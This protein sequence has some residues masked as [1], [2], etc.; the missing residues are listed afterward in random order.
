M[1]INVL[2]QIT[3]TDISI[4]WDIKNWINWIIG[5]ILSAIIGSIWKLIKLPQINANPLA[6]V[7]LK[8]KRIV[9]VTGFIFTYLIPL[10]VIVYVF[11]E[12]KVEN[13]LRNILLFI[14]IFFIL[15]VNIVLDVITPHIIKIYELMIIKSKTD[16]DK[17]KK[18][19]DCF[20]KVYEHIERNK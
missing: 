10:S 7:K 12:N 19:D 20:T 1:F 11:I 6:I 17:L 18:I 2:S 15:F 5:G 9:K 14:L 8:N 16:S 4:V 13:N 3:D